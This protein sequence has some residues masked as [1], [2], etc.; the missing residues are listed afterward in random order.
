MFPFIQTYFSPYGYGHVSLGLFLQLYSRYVVLT[1]DTLLI[2]LCTVL[3]VALCVG[4]VRYRFLA[5]RSAFPFCHRRTLYFLIGATID[6]IT[7]LPSAIPFLA[8]GLCLLLPTVIQSTLA[9]VPVTLHNQHTGN[10]FQHPL[11]RAYRALYQCLPPYSLCCIRY[12]I[13]T[14]PFLIPDNYV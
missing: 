11:S 2:M 1:L 9:T 14:A 3:H 4:I 5:V 10:R 6:G 8:P 7:L 12:G 13:Y